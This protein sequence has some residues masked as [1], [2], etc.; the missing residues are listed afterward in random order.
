LHSIALALGSVFP[1]TMYGRGFGPSVVLYAV[2]AEY[3]DIGLDDKR[4]C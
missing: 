2:S 3:V 1:G 4:G